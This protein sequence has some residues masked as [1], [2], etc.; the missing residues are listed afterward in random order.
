M[1]LT[2]VTTVTDDVTTQGKGQ[3]KIVFSATRFGFLKPR[4]GI[5]CYHV[6][7]S[8]SAAGIR[9]D[10]AGIHPEEQDRFSTFKSFEV[11]F[12]NA[13][14]TMSPTCPTP[15]TDQLY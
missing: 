8:S 7:W 4:T 5:R 3:T 11:E 10:K 6:T 1:N 9:L 2:N 13:E 15:I 12:E 14:S